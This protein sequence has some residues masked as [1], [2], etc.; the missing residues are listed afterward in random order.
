MDIFS[1]EF[2]ETVKNQI[3]TKPKNSKVLLEAI[4]ELTQTNLNN[5][6]KQGL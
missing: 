1:T 6:V 4:K 5:K 3:A 2:L